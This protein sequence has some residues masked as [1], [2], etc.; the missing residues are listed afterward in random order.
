MHIKNLPWVQDIIKNADDVVI[1]C[2]Y[3][4]KE[5][6][7]EPEKFVA[8]RE[9][10]EKKFP[11]RNIQLL[12]Q[13]YSLEDSEFPMPGDKV[14]FFKPQDE[15]VLGCFD[16]D[17]ALSHFA[18]FVYH[19]ESHWKETP[20]RDLLD[21]D[22][23]Y[24][25]DDLNK[26]QPRETF[27]GP[28]RMEYPSYWQMIKSLFRTGK[29][30]IVQGIQDRKVFA[31]DKLQ[32]QRLDICRDCENWVPNSNRCT[33]CGCGMNDKVKFIASDCPIGKW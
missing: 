23:I 28:P 11:N 32:Q 24:T 27:V 6:A 19:C 13:N 25:D 18:Q 1:L 29:N 9:L 31:T 5:D 2:T 33:K 17:F 16:P 14:Y 12:R 15:L 7:A 22:G 10:I 30:V 20:I 8:M 26:Y 3:Q 21:R 4:A